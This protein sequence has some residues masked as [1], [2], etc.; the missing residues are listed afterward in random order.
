MAF[1][2][3]IREY[4]LTYQTTGDNREQQCTNNGT[5]KLS[6]PVEKSGEDGDLAAESQA[7]G[8]GGVD[9]STGDVG[10]D[11]N[12]N[13]QSECMGHSHGHQTGRVKGGVR[14]QLVCKKKLIMHAIRKIHICM[15][16][17]VKK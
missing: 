6:N 11:G 15:H 2:Y 9:V 7:E 5:Q 14:R 16:Q 1:N 4:K 3:K 13:K 17:K 12:S 8:H 10:G